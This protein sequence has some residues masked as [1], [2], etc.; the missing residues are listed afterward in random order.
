MEPAAIC[1]IILNFN[2]T[3]GIFGLGYNQTEK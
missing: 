2:R 3:I 1:Y